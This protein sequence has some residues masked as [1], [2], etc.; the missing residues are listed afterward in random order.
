[1]TG[2]FVNIDDLDIDMIVRVNPFQKAYEILSKSV[3][4]TGPKIIRDTIESTRIDMSF[5]EAKFLWPKV[6]EFVNTFKR[7]PDVNSLDP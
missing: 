1:M 5:E 4:Q 6:N 3:T 2:Q 7:E